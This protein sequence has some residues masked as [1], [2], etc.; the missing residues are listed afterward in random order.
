MSFI[1]QYL[2]KCN[3]VRPYISFKAKF[4]FEDI[5]NFCHS[6][7]QNIID[8]AIDDISKK[9]NNNNQQS[10]NPSNNDL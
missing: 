4:E 5:N 2:A 10:L 8:E 6:Y 7:L 9:E 3:A 1:F